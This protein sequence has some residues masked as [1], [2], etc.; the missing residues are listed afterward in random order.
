[1]DYSWEVDNDLDGYGEYDHRKKVV[2][3]NLDLHDENE[4]PLADTF[5]HE[6]L[7]VAFPE[8]VEDDVVK[9]TM[10]FMV[11]LDGS[12]LGQIKRRY[13]RKLKKNA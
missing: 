9:A 5:I 13:M 12:Q 8:M 4:E 11:L 1:V 6:Q 2:K 10:F 3:I 7:H